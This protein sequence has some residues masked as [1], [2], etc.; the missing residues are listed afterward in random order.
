MVRA[1]MLCLVMLGSAGGFA[2]GQENV[3][4][5]QGNPQG[6]VPIRL[7]VSVEDKSGAP[8]TGLQQRDFTVN[9]NRS[10]AE[11]TSFKQVTPQ[12]EPVHLIV[13]ID[14]V[15][16]PFSTVAYERDQVNRFL[17]ANGG[18]LAYQT[19]FGFV[20]DN[21]ILMG[22]TFTQD[23]NRLSDALEH[24]NQGLR[25]IHRGSQD[26]GFDRAQICLAAMRQL[27]QF[28]GP[29]PG[30]KLV[31]WVSPGW[32][33]L[34]GP[35]IDLDER[36]ERGLFAEVVQVSTELR[37]ADITMYDV[38]PFGAGE[39]LVHADY[40][41][42]FLKGVRNPQDTQIGDLGLQVIAVQSGGM[43]FESNSDVTGQIGRCLKDAQA[44]Y[45]ITIQPARAEKP[46]EFHEVQV[47]VDKGDATARTRNGYYVTR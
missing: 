34:T 2:V 21:G 12:Q 7:N 35:R 44:W 5:P 45:E 36:Q 15:N 27:T 22:K 10:A 29:L 9:D 43:S 33:L 28:A 30:R 32:P 46:E 1:G 47:K 39:S 23:G 41:K 25:T 8:V 40:Y 37:T 19:T 4:G 11:I 20:M 24:Y 38:N 14:A 16:P 26:G 3:P 6:A 31:I 13:L 17:K 18:K 42:E